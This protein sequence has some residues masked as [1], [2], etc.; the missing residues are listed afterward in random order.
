MKLEYAQ[1]VGPD[2]FG[3]DRDEPTVEDIE[4]EPAEQQETSQFKACIGR[5]A[6]RAAV[7]GAIAGGMLVGQGQE[8]AE[9][10]TV[11]TAPVACTKN[12]VQGMRIGS[13]CVTK[14]EIRASGACSKNDELIGEAALALT[15]YM[16]PVANAISASLSLGWT[17][18]SIH[19]GG[20][21]A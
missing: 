8:P 11:P 7:V 16:A 17:S 19:K 1:P 9:A 18:Y 21:C 3:H 6:A 14:Q 2:D 12:G 5:M 20:F 13:L 10:V 4:F 15:L